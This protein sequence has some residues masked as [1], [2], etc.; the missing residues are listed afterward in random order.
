MR[1]F[2]VVAIALLVGG[3]AAAIPSILQPNFKAGS[4]PDGICEL[5]LLPGKLI[6]GLFHDRGAASAEFLWRS[7]MV[8]AVLFSGLAYA[9]FRYRKSPTKDKGRES[10]S[11]PSMRRPV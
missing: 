4:F 1:R 3:A 6:A 11:T 2:Y 8:T 10:S 7:R 5:V 9:G